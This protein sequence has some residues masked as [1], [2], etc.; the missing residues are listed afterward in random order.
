MRG[1]QAR[2]LRLEYEVPAGEGFRRWR[3]QIGGHLIEYGGHVAE[4]SRVQRAALPE[5]GVEAPEE[6]DR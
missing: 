5:A 3:H 1:S 2:V 4:T 6:N